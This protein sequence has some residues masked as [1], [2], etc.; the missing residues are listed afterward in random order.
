M[1]RTG[2]RLKSAMLGLALMATVGCTAQFSNHGYVPSEEDLAAIVVGVDT[3]DTIADEIGTPSAAGILN[4]GGYYYVRSRVK[5]FGPLRPQV[6]E[7]QLVAIGFDNNG[8]VRNVE[9]Y[10]LAD[11]RVVPLS[12]RVTDN[13]IESQNFLRKL[14]KNIGNFNPGQFLGGS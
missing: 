4:E 9:H 8:I 6:V 3:R 1:K 14:L 7:R 5:R 13:G 11:G 10:S 2:I 12:R